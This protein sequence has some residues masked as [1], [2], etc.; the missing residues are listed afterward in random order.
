[1]YWRARGRGLGR[2]VTMGN[3]YGFISI[4]IMRL[5]VFLKSAY[6]CRLVHTHVSSLY[7]QCEASLFLLFAVLTYEHLAI[8]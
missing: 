4:P 6:F 5:L 1:M 2:A 8:W 3:G 7:D